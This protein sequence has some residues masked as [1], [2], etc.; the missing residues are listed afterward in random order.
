ME[1]QLIAAF[2]GKTKLADKL[3]LE[4]LSSESLNQMLLCLAFFVKFK[5][6]KILDYI[7]FQGDPSDKFFIIIDGEAE[8]LIDNLCPESFT[9]KDYF[10]Y[11]VSLWS[12]NDKKLLDKIAKTN[13]DKFP[14]DPR[15]IQN[16]SNLNRILKWKEN[17]LA[18]LDMMH[19]MPCNLNSYIEDL[20]RLNESLKVNMLS[21]DLN[22][23]EFFDNNFHA[24]AHQPFI[25]AKSSTNKNVNSKSNENDIT[26]KIKFEFTNLV[27]ETLQH[28][29]SK[30]LNH[31]SYDH[32]FR[33]NRENI[34][35]IKRNPI[36][37]LV[38]GSF[39]GELGL[40]STKVRSAS[41]RAKTELVL[42][43]ISGHAYNEFLS[44]EST[45]I[46]AKNS[47][48]LL[49]NYFLKNIQRGLFSSKIYPFFQKKIYPKGKILCEEKEE[50][51]KVYFIVSGSIDIIFNKSMNDLYFYYESLVT[52]TYD[53][54][55]RRDGNYSVPE[56]LRQKY[57][58]IVK[59]FKDLNKLFEQ[60][61]KESSESKE[62]KHKREIKVT[63][64]SNTNVLGVM[65]QLLSQSWLKSCVVTSNEIIVF[66]LN[67]DF[68]SR[69]VKIEEI[70][71][72]YLDYA[73]NKLLVYLNHLNSLQLNHYGLIKA[74]SNLARQNQI[75]LRESKC[76][77]NYVKVN[78]FEF[79]A[80]HLKLSKSGA[81]VPSNSIKLSINLPHLGSS[82]E[83]KNCNEK[84]SIS[85]LKIDLEIT[86]IKKLNS[87]LKT[88][89]SQYV[90]TTNNGNK[91]K[92][93]K[94]HQLGNVYSLMVC[95]TESSHGKCRIPSPYDDCFGLA[96][97]SKPK[98]L[99][100]KS[101]ISRNILSY[102]RQ[103]FAISIKKD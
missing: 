98:I 102:A 18:L 11:L 89:N 30:H 26:E 22:L 52:S 62:M 75:N 61:S 91:D 7:F 79:N 49:D 16:I 70:S 4:N 97:P 90:S 8:V 17:L 44:A 58:A 60:L 38:V 37:S 1:T 86:Q 69:L 88:I 15:D 96:K 6:Y 100:I 3:R 54:I 103:S 82:S 57:T 43:A 81:I 87:Q 13:R 71:S 78:A 80:E 36:S 41:I 67:Y 9:C 77:G 93:G 23:I 66:E 29:E 92:L 53:L 12:Q 27:K 83:K 48:I 32:F 25:A 40:D 59:S 50:L 24:I 55:N 94:H 19:D 35:I 46:A 20:S 74:K 33:P 99:S 73:L 84:S 34:T 39:F 65:E 47:Q 72:D 56:H 21:D 28:L 10:Q 68:F 85:N 31:F 76:K 45:K 101:N 95:N 64:A 14:I 42:I 63:S 51:S 2:L 5:T